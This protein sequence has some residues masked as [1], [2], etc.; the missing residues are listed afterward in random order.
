M[1]SSIS[2]TVTCL[3]FYLGGSFIADRISL[4]NEI[5]L[6]FLLMLT[7][8]VYLFQIIRVIPI[9]YRIM[10]ENYNNYLNY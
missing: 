8:V 4:S 9:T 6:V 5:W 2:C 3:A 1:K 7:T 10:N